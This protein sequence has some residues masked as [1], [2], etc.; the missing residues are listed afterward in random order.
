VNLSCLLK[1]NYYL[2]LF[3]LLPFSYSVCQTLEGTTGLFYIPTAEIQKD[4]EFIV[5]T[6][7]VDKELISFGDYKYK[8]YT[9]YL[10][11][12]F[13]PFMEFNVKITRLIDYPL[14]NQG[15]G[16]RTFSIRIRC[17]EEKKLFPAVLV[18]LHDA[19]TVFG[20]T[21]AI[22]NNALYLVCSKNILVQSK[23]LNSFAMHAGYG[24]DILP[25]RTHNFVG[26]FGGISFKMMNFLELM[27]EYDGKR[28]NG[29]IRIKLFNQISILSGYIDYKYFSGGAAF[30]F[31]L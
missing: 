27:S 8:A 31:E 16:D 1:I 14:E 4:G 9:P 7:F 2:L 12:V 10:T 25:A 19:L 17:I 26:I 3:L 18:G 24:F 29:G 23:L 5:G 30:N 22:H 28:N 15:I 13:L 11:F 21:E 6:N 20:G